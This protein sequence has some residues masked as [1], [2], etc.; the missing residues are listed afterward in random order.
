M[1]IEQRLRALGGYSEMQLARVA[2]LHPNPLDLGTMLMLQRQRL[3][4]STGDCAVL[5]MARKK[6][7]VVLCTALGEIA[8]S[9]HFFLSQGP[10][11]GELYGTCAKLNSASTSKSA[12]Q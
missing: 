8:L 4:N 5:K 7:G 3:R 12:K 6:E 2:E 10:S 11:S 1:T 9:F